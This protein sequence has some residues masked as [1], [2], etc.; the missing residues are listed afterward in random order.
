MHIP[1][2]VLDPT[3][4]AV[5]GGM[6][7]A[8]VGYSMYRLRDSLAER[9]IP[10]TGMTASLIFAAQM[11]NF[12]LVVAPVSGHLLG[13]VLAAAI[14]GPWGGCLALS[15][16]LFVQ[17]ALFADGGWMS[18]G[19][20]I[21]NMGVIGCWGGSLILSLVRGLIRDP[22]KAGVIGS[23]WGAWITVMLGAVAF[24]AEFAFS[25]T[26]SGYD[27]GRLF[28]MMLGFHALIGIGEAIITGLILKYLIQV[29]PD[30]VT[31]T[32]PESQSGH[33]PAGKNPAGK[34][35]ARGWIGLT[36]AGLILAIVIVVVAAPWASSHPDGLEAVGEQLKFNDLSKSAWSV[37]LDDYSLPWLS[38][39]WEGVGTALVGLVGTAVVFLLTILLTRGLKPQAVQSPGPIS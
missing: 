39:R 18:L 34:N 26:A 1:D 14:L 35:P 17:V 19:A 12:P 31:G 38:E 23:I 28:F 3:V 9:T 16:V 7:A 27:L 15:M 8:A 21:L 13:G 33:N 25:S 11:V 10:V 22:M 29:R 24:C 20:N 36:V 30:L 2:G 6:A 5:T 37:W 4:C 32:S